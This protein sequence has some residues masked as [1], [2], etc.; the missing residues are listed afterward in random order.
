MKVLIQNGHLIDPATGRNAAMDLLIE[1][2]K[3]SQIAPLIGGIEADTVINASGKLV[4]PGFIDL[5]VHLREPGFEYKETI[6]TGA[7]AAAR[8]GFTTICPMPNTKPV[9]DSAEMVEF[10]K[11]KAEK[12]A[13]VNIVPVG[14]VTKGQEGQ[15]LSDIAAMKN[16][17]ALALSEDGKSVMDAALYREALKE[18]KKNDLVMLAHCE[19][20]SLA[21]KGVL[22]AGRKAEEL[23]MEGISNAVEDVIVARDILLAKETGA[24]LH[25][26]H[27]STKDSVDIV[28]WGR[29][30]GVSVTAEVCPH[31]FT[32]TDE[33]ITGDDANFKMN[34]PL[35][36]RADVDALKKALSDNVMS[37]I[38]TDHAPHSAEEKA[39]SI[40]DAPFG[41]VG[42]ETAYALGVTELVNKGWLTHYQLCEKMSKNP[43]RVLGI[44]RGSLAVGSV[45]DIVI[46][47]PEAE[48]VIDASQFVSMGHNTPFHGKKVKGKICYTLVAGNIVYEGEQ[49]ND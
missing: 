22:N 44:E 28:A 2:G 41:I 35:R 16:A 24:R 34:P 46:T 3:V 45:A 8:G 49:D 37:V 10:I 13:V 19:D 21:G 26:C 5:H 7:L 30:Q 15:E 18:M 4:M 43:A 31:H 48:Y 23:Q 1:D 42:L 32:M 9:I 39:R 47:D 6:K 14:S 29:K 33:E 36:S 38:A 20:K 11:D 17:G 27:C 25:L 12:E 40:K